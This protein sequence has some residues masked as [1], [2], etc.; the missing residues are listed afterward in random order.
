VVWKT[1]LPGWS[2]AS[3][4]ILGDRLYVCSEPATLICVALKDGAI[5]WTRTN[6]TLDILP[7]EE[8]EKAKA[9]RAKA[10]DVQARTKLVKEEAA[11]TAGELKKTPDDAEL[12]AKSEE[13][14]RKLDSLNAELKQYTAYL[15][16]KTHEGNGYSTPTP[17]TDGKAI[18]VLFGNGV[19]A[20]Y[21]ADGNRRWARVI[22]KPTHGWG[23]SASPLTVEGKVIVHIGKLT[24]LDQASGNTLW[25]TD[26]SQA[27]GSM[28]LAKIGEAVV[29]VTASGDIIRVSDGHKL[30][31][32]VSGLDYCTPVVQDDIVYFIQNGGK[33]VR[34]PKVMA[35]KIEPEVL[36]T[37]KPKSDRYYASPVVHNGLIYA[38]TQK[39]DWSV[40]DAATGQ[41]VLEKNIGL[42]GTFY[43][44]V[45]LAGDYLF[46]S[47]DNGKT[48]ALVPGREYKEEAR[49]AVDSFRSC[50]V[51]AGSRLY[52][53][54]REYLWCMG[55]ADTGK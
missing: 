45:T 12:K 16:P 17:A 10:D 36:W 28:I 39:G 26:S 37:T 30:A 15:E 1:R 51:F 34:L 9:D 27:W 49:S 14:K 48:V 38:V 42:G 25:Q 53:R 32:K 19:A 43:P 46:V 24:A 13:L 23:H 40:I 6:S 55:N 20:C 21:D 47:S 41:V 50:P 35:D 3:P 52:L 44:S 2:N 31:A 8:L 11:R 33:A 7:A 5:L 22:E 54:G 18:Y 29:V 4:L